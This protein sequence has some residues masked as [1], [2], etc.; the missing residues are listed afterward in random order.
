MP[1]PRSAAIRSISGIAAG[2][3]RMSTGR[4]PAGSLADRRA[5]GG[6]VQ[7]ER[8]RVDVAEHGRRALVQQAVRRG[9]EAERAGHHLVSVSPAEGP[10]PE[11]QGARSR[12]DGHRVVDAE[13]LGEPALESLEHRAQ[14]EPRRAHHLEDQ[15]LLARPQVGARERKEAR[16]TA[17]RLL[18]SRSSHWPAT[19][20]R[21]FDS[22]PASGAGGVRGRTPGWKA[23]SSESTSA[24]QEASMM[25]S[26]TPID[27]PA[28]RARPRSPGGPG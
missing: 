28:R 1:R 25:F 27:A 8:H 12:R 16:I 19:T 18:R 10:D 6:R 9:R 23:Y 15:L 20:S 2:Y 11:V 24:S 13:P 7:V 21:A 14:R 26:E 22:A 4:K 3:P 5:G 17:R